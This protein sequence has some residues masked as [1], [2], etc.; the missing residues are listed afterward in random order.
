MRL[1]TR[2]AIGFSIVAAL[3]LIALTF[4]ARRAL[5]S[6][7]EGALSARLDGATRAAELALQDAQRESERATRRIWP[8]ASRSSRWRK[9]STTARP[10]QR[11]PHA[12][13][14]A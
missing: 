3:P 7:V 6:A 1:R 10:I 8:R 5:S 14:R 4:P 12:S 11:R 2:L 9:R 13:P